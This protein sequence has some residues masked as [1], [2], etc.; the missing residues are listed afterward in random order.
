MS[1]EYA[2]KGESV[3]CYANGNNQP[4]CVEHVSQAADK[5]FAPTCHDTQDKEKCLDYER[6]ASGAPERR[7]TAARKTRIRRAR[8]MKAAAVSWCRA[9][10]CS[11]QCALQLN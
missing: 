7:P 9:C 6:K 1:A 5:D 2:S 11:L 10:E 8:R 3:K 4:K